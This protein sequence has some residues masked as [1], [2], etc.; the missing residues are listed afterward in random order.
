MAALA[1]VTDKILFPLNRETTRIGRGKENDICIDGQEVST[2]HALLETQVKTDKSVDYYIEDLGSTNKTYVNGQ[3]I[4]RIKLTDDDE[5][6]IGWVVLKF[7]DESN[8]DYIRTSKIYKSWIPGV[9]Y[10]R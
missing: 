10:T 3:E 4:D 6:R 5:I 1:Q 2:A 8:P 7:I 9:Y